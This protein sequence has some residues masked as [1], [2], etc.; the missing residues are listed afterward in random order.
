VP[1]LGDERL[2]LA[3]GGLQLV[4]L[5]VLGGT[6]GKV[7]LACVVL[8]ITVCA[9]AVHAAT[10]RLMFTMARDGTLPASTAL[11]RVS[12]VHRTPVVPPS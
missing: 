11:A 3:S 8:A 5:Q 2:G 9:L 10:I 7:F 1:D 6:L 12:P 4:V